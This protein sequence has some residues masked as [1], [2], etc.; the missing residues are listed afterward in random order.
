MTPS[1]HAPAPPAP[2]DERRAF[3]RA[4]GLM[5]GA[6]VVLIALFVAFYP[7]DAEQGITKQQQVDR[8]LT[9]APHIIPTPAEG[10]APDNPGDPGGWEQLA[11]FGV[12]VAGLGLVV[13][14]VW[15]SSRKAR[16]AKTA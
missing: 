16:R 7:R 2:K 10:R 1:V 4:A 14:L 13:F 11:L 6:L 12:I 8:A 5:T 3:W 9:Q 15:R